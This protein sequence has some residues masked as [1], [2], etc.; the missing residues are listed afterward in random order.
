MRDYKNPP[1]ISAPFC[2]VPTTYAPP[3]SPSC[4]SIPQ[5]PQ[6]PQLISSVEQAILNL[7]KLVGDVVEEQKKFNAQLSQKI[8]IVENSLNQKVDGFQSEIGQKFD[9]LLKSISSLAQ[10]HDY[11]E[12]GN[13]KR[14]CLIN[15]ILS[16][17]TQLQQLL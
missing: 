16:E 7:T 12:E 4:A 15:T 13:S 17:Q 1:W 11:Q 2:S 10:Q 14:E 8:H 5:S 3:A 6:P 9:N